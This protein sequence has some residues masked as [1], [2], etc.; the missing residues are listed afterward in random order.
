MPINELEVVEV[1]Q[2]KVDIESF[3]Q[4]EHSNT[5]LVIHWFEFIYAEEIAIF[6]LL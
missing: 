2:I 3:E 1:D 4:R 5:R 6:S